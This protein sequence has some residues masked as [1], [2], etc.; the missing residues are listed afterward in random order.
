MNEYDMQDHVRTLGYDEA[1]TWL[2]RIVQEKGADYVYSEDKRVGRTEASKSC[3]N[4]DNDGQPSCIVGHLAIQGGYV[5]PNSYDQFSAA[6]TLFH[7]NGIE[8]DEKAS[9]LLYEVQR[10]QDMSI[11][12]G[13]S[14]ELAKQAVARFEASLNEWDTGVVL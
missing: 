3:A 8:L 9:I 13:Q 10:Q 7:S 6:G 11:P 14:L 4:W 5:Q 2:E 12:W 1:L